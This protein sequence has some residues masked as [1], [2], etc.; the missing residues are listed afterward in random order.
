MSRFNDGF[1]KNPYYNPAECSLELIGVLEDDEPWQ[2]DMVIVVK[3]KLDGKLYAAHD[4]GCSCPTPFEGIEELSDMTPITTVDDL[5]RF[6]EVNES[7]YEQKWSFADR[8]ALY[9]KVRA[10]LS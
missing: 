10:A 6:V 9:K 8:T 5:K 7:E 4:S 3:D 1:S 2:F